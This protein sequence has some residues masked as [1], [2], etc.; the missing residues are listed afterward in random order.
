[1][2][3]V[4]ALLA[5]SV[6]VVSPLS[7]SAQPDDPLAVVQAFEAALNAGDLDAA[8]ALLSS[9]AQVIFQGRPGE[10]EVLTGQ[11]EIREIF[12]GVTI[13]PGPR[14]VSSGTVR[15]PYSVSILFP[16]LVESMPFFQRFDLDP[17][18]GMIE[19]TVQ[20]GR[21]TSFTILVD[22][23]FAERTDAAWAAF[24]AAGGALA[25]LRTPAGEP[26]GMAL[27]LPTSNGVQI[28]VRAVGLPPGEHGIHLHAVGRCEG[29]DFT[30]A[31]GHYNPTQR[32]HGL[33]NPVG[34]HAGDLPNLTV[35]ADGTASLDASAP[36]MMPGLLDA[37]GAALVI[38]AAPDDQF[39]DPTGNSGAR[40][41]CGVLESAET[42][43]APAQPP[44]APTPAPARPA[45]PTPTPA[46]RP[47]VPVQVPAR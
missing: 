42:P 22:P 9:N 33:S 32:E 43:A 31:G 24:E 25:D 46:P 14:Q 30:S 35:A 21:I 13:T 36:A 1:L 15:Y 18:P 10:R 4:A 44:V 17:Q 45:V 41:A 20:N 2:L 26:A 16:R 38:H 12:E 37:D 34:H 19:A 47:A 40:I 28:S 5:M 23:E 8:L 29:P 6:F 11:A 3:V 7:S 39:T 27:V